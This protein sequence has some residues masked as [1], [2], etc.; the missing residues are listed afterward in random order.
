MKNIASK[1]IALAMLALS[2]NAFSQLLPPGAGDGGGG[3][4]EPPAD[5]RRNYTK[6]MNQAF[7][8]IDTNAAA[9]DN[10]NLYNACVSFPDTTN[11]ALQ[12]VAYGTS[13]VI[14][15]ASHFDYSTETDRDFALLVCDSLDEPVW[16]DILFSGESDDQDG[17]LVQG[18][19]PHWQVTDTM[20]FMISNIVH[21][22]NAFY[23]V[24]PYDG[25]QIQLTGPQPYDVVSNVISIHAAIKDLS[26]ITNEQ[27]EVTVDGTPTRY[28]L[29]T[30]NTISLDTRYNP[31]GPCNVDLEVVNKASIYD[32]TNVLADNAK[33]YFSGFASMP[34][35]FENDTYLD[36]ASDYA[37][38]DI[39]TNYFLFVVN[40]AQNI[41]A[42]ITD[43]ANGQTVATYGGYVP[44]ATTIELEWNFTESDGV[45]PYSND[46]YVVTFTAYDPVTLTITNKIDRNGV[47]PGAGCYLTY[48]TEDPLN[49]TGNYLNQQAD[50]WINQ[51]LSE[52]YNDMYESLSLTQ[53]TPGTVGANR[54]HAACQ[55]LDASHVDWQG[56]LKPALSNANYSDLTIAQAH[57][58]G[59]SIG[60]GHYLAATF[61]PFDLNSWC[62]NY[63]PSKNWRLRKAAIWAC[64]S[65]DITAARIYYT[66]PDACGIRPAGIQNASYMRKNCGLFFGGLLPQ[67]GFGGTTATTA[68]VAEFLDQ[69]WICGQDEY[70][71]GCDPTYSFRFAINATR[72]MYDP[73][74]S[75]ADLRLFGFRDMIYSSVYDD[76]LMM[77]N[78]SHVKQP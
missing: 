63:T 21:D 11:T 60:G 6:F 22:C 33:I 38:P 18:T 20:F 58:S 43:P 56:F 26:G 64:Y 44:Y 70:P 24:I 35:D 32:P 50:T 66:F 17:W 39:G 49:Y 71:G 29:E 27:F 46:T 72:T 47:R 1:I 9:T 68:K 14:I 55:P 42:T 77:L 78:T 53:Y 61:T 37:S 2:F 31:A 3:F 30:N 25:P 59:S 7:S 10:T 67:G 28:S 15:K 45:T 34:L 75:S 36:F 69:A 74:L 65:G 51:T 76:E 41:G 13:A 12:V 4:S 52:L 73:E 16:K 48:E 5:T 54:N 57:G 19:V 23:Q 8:I 40:K 62:L